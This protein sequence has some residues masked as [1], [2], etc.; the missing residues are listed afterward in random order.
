MS[1]ANRLMEQGIGATQL[2]WRYLGGLLNMTI[3]DQPQWTSFGHER[4]LLFIKD[5]D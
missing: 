5:D 2:D 1:S 3:V 4:S